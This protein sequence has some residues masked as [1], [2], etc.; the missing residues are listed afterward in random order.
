VRS[1][2]DYPRAI[3]VRLRSRASELEEAIFDR[4]IALAGGALG[5]DDASFHRRFILRSALDYG[6]ISTECGADHLP[7]VPP[8]LLTHAR[9]SASKAVPLQELLNQYLVGYSLFKDL[10]LEEHER[11]RF[12]IGPA[13]RQVL[14]SNDVAFER[15]VQ[16]VSY[17]HEKELRLRARSKATRQL[18]LVEELLSGQLVEAPDLP[19][20]LE[21]THVAIVGTG[22]GLAAIIRSLAQVFGIQ[23]LLVCPSPEKVWAWLGSRKGLHSADL[24]SHLP[25][26]WP[27]DVRVAIG[28]PAPQLIGWRRSHRQAIAA[29][30]IGVQGERGI[31]RY[32]EVPLLASIAMD[33]L[34]QVSLQEMYLTPLAIGRDSGQAIRETLRAY[35]AAGRNGA[36]AA[37]ALGL[38]RQTIAQR[39]HQAEERLGQPLKD[40]AEALYTA[41]QLEELGYISSL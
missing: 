18:D 26:P 8:A 13:S 4:L 16:A 31:V 22:Q 14:R 9:E 40:C 2:G 23:R 25:S 27:P 12:S 1:S 35:F 34:L 19:Y 20:N 5:R 38:S 36:S 32:A 28:E 11:C 21:G 29:L 41:L 6:F 30:A 37:A 17:E 24:V 33:N 39:L 15:L 10:V 7:S 3:A